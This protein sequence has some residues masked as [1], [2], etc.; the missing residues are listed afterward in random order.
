M[1][2]RRAT[3]VA[4][5]ASLAALVAATPQVQS[6]ATAAKKAGLLPVGQ[7]GELLETL[8]QDTTAAFPSTLD[9]LERVRA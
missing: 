1:G 2:W 7:A 8:A 5:P 6:M 4:L 3:D 9:D